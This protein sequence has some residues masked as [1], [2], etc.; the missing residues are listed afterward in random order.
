VPAL[1]LRVTSFHGEG[2]LSGVRF[3]RRSETE[4]GLAP[5]T[6]CDAAHANATTASHY[7]AVYTF[8]R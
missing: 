2:I 1:L 5:A 4:G 8:Y 3:V 6:G 7:S